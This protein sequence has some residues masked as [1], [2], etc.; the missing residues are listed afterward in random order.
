MVDSGNAIS[1]KIERGGQGRA[2]E[3]RPLASVSAQCGGSV[4]VLV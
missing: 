3:D 1:G 2:D 4:L